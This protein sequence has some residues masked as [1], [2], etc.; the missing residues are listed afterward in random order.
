[1]NSTT[2]EAVSRTVEEMLSVAAESAAE[3]GLAGQAD[4]QALRA[5]LEARVHLAAEEH[6]PLEDAGAL[7]VREARLAGEI[8]RLE[9]AAVAA[10]A[11]VPADT[12]ATAGSTWTPRVTPV[13]DL[14]RL[15]RLG[16]LAAAV[17]FVGV[18][19]Q[20]AGLIG[21]RG[22][23]LLVAGVA[24]G[25]AAA[26]DVADACRRWKADSRAAR[27]A[28]DA[29]MQARQRADAA[30]AAIAAAQHDLRDLHERRVAIGATRTR[31][32]AWIE[33]TVACLST[34]IDYQHSRAMQARM[35]ADVLTRKGAA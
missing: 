15:R 23:I 25:V 17:V 29:R 32:A 4:S 12:E 30:R 10:E 19:L 7:E 26:P 6:F 27:R 8:E 35:A 20:A 5:R 1:M 22:W 14:P 33:T 16:A 2:N 24:G 28:R 21:M 34:E 9:C 31:R 11:A 3:A 18:A 13:G